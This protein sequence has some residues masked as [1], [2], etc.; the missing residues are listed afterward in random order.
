MSRE[1]RELVDCGDLGAGSSEVA[2]DIEKIVDRVECG[3]AVGCA[4][5]LKSVGR[6]EAEA[7]GD[8]GEGG[9]GL[10]EESDELMER[11]VRLIDLGSHY[12]LA[13]WAGLVRTDA[14]I[15]W[16]DLSEVLV[17]AGEE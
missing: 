9:I 8:V 14:D 13:R 4:E 10:G 5:K 17:G 11:L 6:R 15:V 16:R 3:G 7:V 1:V 2:S 12:P